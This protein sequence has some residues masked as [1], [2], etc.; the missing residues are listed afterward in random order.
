MTVK[1]KTKF[2][3]GYYLKESIL[4]FD[5]CGDSGLVQAHSL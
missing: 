4:K 2:N 5:F 1:I 3:Y